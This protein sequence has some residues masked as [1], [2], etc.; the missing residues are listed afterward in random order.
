MLTMKKGNQQTT[1][2]PI[3]RPIVKTALYSPLPHN[4]VLVPGMD[5]RRYTPSRLHIFFRF[6][7]ATI[8]IKYENYV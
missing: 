3:M 6:C 2:V 1:K 8:K 5:A 7:I 4:K